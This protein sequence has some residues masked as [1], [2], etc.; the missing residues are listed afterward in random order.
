MLPG[1]APTSPLPITDRLVIALDQLRIARRM[2]D[3]DQEWAWGEMLDRLLDKL[4]RS[5]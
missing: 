4:P 1:D 3:H 2:G 5:V